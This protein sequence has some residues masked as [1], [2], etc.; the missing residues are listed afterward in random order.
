MGL[1]LL[2][3]ALRDGTAF[4]ECSWVK[5]ERIT[6]YKV[7]VPATDPETGMP[8]V[9]GEWGASPQVPS[10]LVNAVTAT[11]GSVQLVNLYEYEN[12]PGETTTYGLVGTPA[13]NAFANAILGK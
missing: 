11:A 2:H 12:Q 13:F 5:D 6:R 4:M 1:L 9:V 3:M 7:R 8:V 10:D